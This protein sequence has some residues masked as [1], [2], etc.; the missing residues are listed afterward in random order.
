M[1]LNKDMRNHLID[2]I[3]DDFPKD[4][5]SE[6]IKKF[7]EKRA[8]ETLPDI[9]R[10]AFDSGYRD[11]LKEGYVHVAGYG[12]VWTCNPRYSITEADWNHL[13]PLIDADNNHREN[14]KRAIRELS[15]LFNGFTT[16]EQIE[17]QVPEFKRYTDKLLS[18]Y[19]RTE[20]NL[21]AVSG[22]IDRMIELGFK[23]DEDNENG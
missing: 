12:S 20:K 3:M 7:I 2:M 17:R 4:D 21:P 1:R 14:R 9:L 15:S 22:V 10:D 8:Y 13:K 16:T 19:I 18:H 6:K 11:Y 5:F 23:F